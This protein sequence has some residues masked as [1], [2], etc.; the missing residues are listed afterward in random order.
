MKTT[1]WVTKDLLNLYLLK[2]QVNLIPRLFYFSHYWVLIGL[3]TPG[4]EVKNIPNF[5]INLSGSEMDLSVLIE[6]NKKS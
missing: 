2:V 6:G 1:E 3:Y 4:G 5:S